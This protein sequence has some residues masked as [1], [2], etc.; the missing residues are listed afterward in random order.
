M[1][2]KPITDDQL[3]KWISVLQDFPTKLKNLTGSLNNEQIDTAYREGGWT[4]RQVV[5][6]LADSHMNSYI[7]FKW[8][9]TE[10]EPVIKAYFEK[11]WA[12]LPDSFNAPIELS[13]NALKGLHTKWVYL[14]KSLS[15]DDLNRS[16]VH[17]ETK[18]KIS[19][20]ENIGIYAW[21]SEHHYAHIENLMERKGWL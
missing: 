14:L 5:H 1:I 20:K 19:I 4:V 11:R 21:H 17:P 13:V 3:N 8:A 18:Q 7:R 6:H 15:E 2:T 10:Q 9:L 12:E 16:F